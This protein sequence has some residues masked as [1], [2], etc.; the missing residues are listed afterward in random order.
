RNKSQFYIDVVYLS[1]FQDLSEVNQWNWGVAALTYLQ[2]Y[3]DDSCKAGG[4][5][6]A[7]YLSFY[8]GWIM[9][10]FPKMTVWHYDP[11]YRE[12]M[13][14]NATF[15]TGQGHRDHVLYRQF[16]DNMQER[17]IESKTFT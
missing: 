13:P 6:V 15:S 10:H 9:M 4:G 11:N 16:L 14:R 12:E 17:V 7:G 8:Q 3:L 5:Q 1:Y 2:H